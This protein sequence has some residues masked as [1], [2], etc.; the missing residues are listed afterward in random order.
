MVRSLAKVVGSEDEKHRKAGTNVRKITSRRHAMNYVSKYAAKEASDGYAVGRR[1]GDEL[2]DWTSRP[3]AQVDLS[4]DEWVLL[5]RIIRG[6]AKIAGSLYHKRLGL[7][8]LMS[9]R[10][11]SVWAIT[12]LLTATFARTIFRMPHVLPAKNRLSD[13]FGMKHGA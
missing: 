3:S 12:R 7:H 8:L 4:V 2:G 6:W 5:K 13:W 10:S 9:A 1:W 11:S